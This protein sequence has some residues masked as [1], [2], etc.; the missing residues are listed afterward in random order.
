MSPSVGT[1]CG[2]GA[3][4][5]GAG[6]VVGFGLVGAGAG[7]VVGFVVGVAVALSLG[8]AG[9]ASVGSLVVG[10]ALGVS[11]EG[12]SA[13]VWSEE[14]GAAPATG[15]LDEALA[16]PTDTMPHPLRAVAATIR[17]VARTVVER[18]GSSRWWVMVSLSSL[19]GEAVPAEPH[20]G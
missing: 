7:F 9:V 6:L 11:A 2:F 17:P 15:P 20:T 12:V 4:G 1:G 18:R 16:L 5:V 13:D 10:S 14:D 3:V 8:T 19:R